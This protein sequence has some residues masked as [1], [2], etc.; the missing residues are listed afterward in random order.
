MLDPGLCPEG[1]RIFFDMFGRE[2]CG[3][4]E[5]W[6]RIN[7]TCQLLYKRGEC[8]EGEIVVERRLAVQRLK[9]ECGLG[10]SCKE[11][12]ECSAYQK[13]VG[14]VKSKDEEELVNEYMEQFS[15][16]FGNFSF[17]WSN[18]NIGVC[19]PNKTQH[20]FLTPESILK[21]IDLETAAVCVPTPCEEG[22][23]VFNEDSDLICKEPD[24]LYENA[25]RVRS[26]F[27]GGMN[28][29]RRKVWSERRG[30]CIRVFA[31]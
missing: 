9:L 19:C 31:G 12:T 21:Q 16:H 4:E 23:E 20:S 2:S 27:Q 22:M 25:P 13:D 17:A 29:G 15:C 8:G 14:I 10:W 3:C 1:E 24:Q 18:E 6:G 30:K 5:G 7:Q 11:K 28:C 26:I